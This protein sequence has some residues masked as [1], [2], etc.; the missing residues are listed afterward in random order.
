[1]P[2]DVN[3]QDAVPVIRNAGALEMAV[4]WLSG[5][6]FNNVLLVLIFFA[7]GWGLHYSVTIAIPAHLSQIQAGY[8]DVVADCYNKH[9]QERKI[10]LETYDRWIELIHSEKLKKNGTPDIAKEGSSP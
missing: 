1:M 3:R 9:E 8:K 7:I 5:Q 4:Q 6:S 10:T 2:D